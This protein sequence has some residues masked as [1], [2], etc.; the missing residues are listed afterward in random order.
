M[1][2]WCDKNLDMYEM[3][4]A[5]RRGDT[6]EGKSDK[7]LHTP[8]SEW[9]S[10]HPNTSLPSLHLCAN[11]M[12]PNFPP[13]YHTYDSH[14]PEHNY[15]SPHSTD[16]SPMQHP[17]VTHVPI[18][19][20]PYSSHSHTINLLSIPWCLLKLFKRGSSHTAYPSLPCLS[21]RL[22]LR[23]LPTFSPHSLLLPCVA[24]CM[25]WYAHSSWELWVTNYLC[26]LIY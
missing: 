13:T 16:M 25:I 3:Q 19:H 5:A 20:H 17:H 11:H 12:P 22:Q 9:S 8:S 4:S 18:T 2:S 6:G 7:S 14:T 21:W 26:F 15:M 23:F 10:R 1:N 24:P